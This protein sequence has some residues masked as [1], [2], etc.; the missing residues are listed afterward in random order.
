MN[1]SDARNKIVSYIGRRGDFKVSSKRAKYWFKVLNVAVFDSE[2]TV[3][4]FDIRALNGNVGLCHHDGTTTITISTRIQDKELFI[5]TL[6]HEMVHQYQQDTECK[7]HHGRSFKDWQLYI[8]EI[9]GF[10]I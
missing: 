1:A 2:L 10:T 7:M 4:E 8:K 9:L 5:A 3:P 6:A